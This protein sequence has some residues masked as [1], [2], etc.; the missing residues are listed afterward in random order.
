MLE[1]SDGVKVIFDYPI[2]IQR[3]RILID[4][5]AVVYCDHCKGSID[6]IS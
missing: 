3:L 2:C 6:C 4:K 1:V 5:K